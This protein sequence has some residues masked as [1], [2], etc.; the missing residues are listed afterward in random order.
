MREVRR[1]Q[2]VYVSRSLESSVRLHLHNFTLNRPII[3]A[4][5]AIELE[6]RV[7]RSNL[8]VLLTSRPFINLSFDSSPP[9]RRQPREKR[10]CPL[11]LSIN[12]LGNNYSQKRILFFPFADKRWQAS[13]FRENRF[14]K[15]HSLAEQVARWF[16][17]RKKVM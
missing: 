11:T 2:A 17:I 13:Y 15:D 9:A 8:L 10:L 4:R 3:R 1:Y 5:R 16:A 6:P 12:N 14:D 7:G